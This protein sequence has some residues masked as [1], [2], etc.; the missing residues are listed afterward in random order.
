MSEKETIED[1]KNDLLNQEMEELPPVE[2]EEEGIAESEPETKDEFKGKFEE[3]NDKYIRLYSEF[4]NYRRRTAREKIELITNAGEDMLKILIPVLDDFDRAIAN[5]EKSD[6][7]N[8]VKEG[9]KLVYNKFKKTLTDKG[10]KEMEMNDN[11]FNVDLHEAITKIPAPDNDLKG[12]V[13][14]VIEKG[15]LL[16]EKVIRY[17]KVVVGE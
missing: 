3:I 2:M 11:S 7:I 4:D 16:N 9:V 8:A 17:A 10:L 1:E 14:D 6:D 5:N 15:Y 13:I 12:K